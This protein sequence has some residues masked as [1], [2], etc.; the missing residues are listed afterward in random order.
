MPL[1]SAYAAKTYVITRG[2]ENV[3]E[4]A[5]ARQLGQELVE[6]FTNPEIFTSYTVTANDMIRINQYKGNAANPNANWAN[7]REMIFETTP[8]SGI[9]N[10]VPRGAWD[11]QG[12]PANVVVPAGQTSYDIEVGRKFRYTGNIA[13]P[14][15]E[16]TL[17]QDDVDR[18][19]V[20]QGAAFSYLTYARATTAS[21]AQ[22]QTLVLYRNKNVQVKN[23][24]A[25][26]ATQYKARTRFNLVSLVGPSFEKYK[27]DGKV[28]VKYRY[29]SPRTATAG[30]T[31][32]VHATDNAGWID[33]TPWANSFVVGS[34]DLTAGV[35]PFA[36]AAANFMTSGTYLGN[37]GTAVTVGPNQVAT[38]V[39]VTTGAVA[40]QTTFANGNVV[41]NWDITSGSNYGAAAVATQ[42]GPT[43]L[44]NPTNGLNPVVN[45]QWVPRYIQT[46]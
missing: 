17:T 5:N 28:Y 25:N 33:I 18:L 3:S 13:Q 6:T 11:F 12:R 26:F 44:T 32:V 23:V 30:N 22:G 36:A 10:L 27:Q 8:N 29:Y 24:A 7:N 41:I 14:T 38:A 45:G 20:D 35:N 21:V 43:T 2:F 39:N 46:D 31:P 16:F 9:F 34:Y 37:A 40:D 42:V 19:S 4:V 15:A 1:G